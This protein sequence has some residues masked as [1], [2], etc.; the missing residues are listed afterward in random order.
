MQIRSH[1][2]PFKLTVKT[3]CTV[4]TPYNPRWASTTTNLP[5]ETPLCG[6]VRIYLSRTGPQFSS[7]VY[8]VGKICEFC[9]CKSKNKHRH[10]PT[11]KIKKCSWYLFKICVLG[12]KWKHCYCIICSD[13]HVGYHTEGIWAWNMLHYYQ[14]SYYSSI[15]YNAAMYYRTYVYFLSACTVKFK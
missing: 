12:N 7:R 8:S 11:R 6:P 15:I 13:N 2:S 9:Q 14:H 10:Q 1:F 5:P 3:I 4:K